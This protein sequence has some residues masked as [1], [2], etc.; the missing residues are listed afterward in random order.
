MPSDRTTPVR[1]HQ[2]L[3]QD[4]EA[5]V[6]K[7]F[8]TGHL[9]QRTRRGHEGAEGAPSIGQGSLGLTAIW[10]SPRLARCGSRSLQVGKAL[11]PPVPGPGGVLGSALAWPLSARLGRRRSCDRPSR[12]FSLPRTPSRTSTL[13]NLDPRRWG[14]TA[15]HRCSVCDHPIAQVGL[16]QVWISLRVATDVLPL[17]VSACSSVCVAELPDG[18]GRATSPHHTQAAESISRRPT[19]TDQPT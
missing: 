13:E 17:L 2:R 1:A 16:H 3:G 4:S 12:G 6:R 19:G 9:C 15:I 14:A 10:P 7:S 18:A 11:E 8:E 5:R